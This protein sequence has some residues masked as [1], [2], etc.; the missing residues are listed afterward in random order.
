VLDRVE[1]LEF[2]VLGRRTSLAPWDLGAA[3][4]GALLR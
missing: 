1:A 4:A 3:A 2:D